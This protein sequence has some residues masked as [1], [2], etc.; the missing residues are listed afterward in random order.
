MPWRHARRRCPEAALVRYERA[1][2]TPVLE[3][4]GNVMA[5]A[6]P[7]VEP[8]PGEEGAF[9]ASLGE[10]SLEEG[11]DLALRIRTEVAQELNL[12]AH[13]GL[14]TG[15]IT[16]RAVG[17]SGGVEERRSGRKGEWESGRVGEPEQ[18]QIDNCQFAIVNSGSGTSTLPLLHTSTPPLFRSLPPGAE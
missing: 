7:W 17:E 10:G 11:R 9:F 1:A 13:L 18:L 12:P 8:M 5:R 15:K 16:A 2:Y 4:I 14:A 3:Q 6:T